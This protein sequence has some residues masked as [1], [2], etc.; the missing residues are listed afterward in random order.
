MDADFELLRSENERLCRRVAELERLV[1]ELSAANERLAA[2]L[3]EA[4]RAGKRQA[5]PFRKSGGPKPEPKKPGR[6]PGDEHGPHAH[7]A[8]PPNAID[9]THEAGLPCACPDCGGRRFADERVVVQYQTEIPRRP[10]VRQFNIHVARC[11]GCGGAV[12]GRH[13]LQTSDAVGAAASQLGAEA[14]AALALLNKQCGLSHGKCRDVLRELFGITIARATSARS[15]LRTARRCTAAHE[16]LRID[17]RNSPRVVPDETGWR[18]GGKT[19]WL[20]AFV[21]VDATCY[22]V[23]PT[24]GHEP[25]ERLLG[26]DWC[27]AMT[28]DGWAVYDRFRCATHQQCTAHLLRRCHEMLEAATG[29]AARFPRRVKEILQHGLRLRDRFA[30]GDM[31]AHGMYVMAGRLRS[32]MESLV[33]PIKRHAANERFAKFLEA[34]LNDLFTYLRRPEVD[35][36]NWRGEHAIRPAVVNRKVWGGNRTWHGAAAQSIV[37]SILRTLAQRNHA[38]LNW[39]ATT[40]RR[41]EPLLIPP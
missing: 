19:A 15:V 1:A 30:A 8:A 22:E 9:E 6:K 16:Q 31:T 4:R 41:P 11:R 25:A 28:H 14:H 29:M 40:L 18:V 26:R 23:D 24:R 32:Q 2:Q 13:E 10:I 27:G 5:A 3:D 12:Q 7:R 36:T 20:H 38:A 35:A 37:S 33:A 17:V 39:L 34:H 21:G